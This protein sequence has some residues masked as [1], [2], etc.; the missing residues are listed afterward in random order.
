MLIMKISK[1]NR[2]AGLA[3]FIASMVFFGGC[4]EYLVELNEN[5]NGAEPTSTHPNL[6]LPTVLS[7]TSKLYLNLGYQDLAGVMQH[8]QK[9]GWNGSHN[10]YDWEG[11][12]NW[13]GYYDILRNNKF[14]LERSEELGFEMHQGVA[15]VMKSFVFGLMADL[16]GDVPY[17]EA[18]LA[19]QGGTM[20]AKYD[21]QED[22]YLGVIADLEQANQLLSK[23]AAQYTAQLGNA[24]LYFNGNPVKWRQFANSLMLRYYMRLSHK[25]PELAK[26]GIEKIVQNPNDY[27]IILVA[28]DDVTMGFPGTNAGDSWPFNL[29]FDSSDQ[30][31]NFRRIKMAHTLVEHMRA[32]QDPRL[33][34]W[35]ARVQIP[36]SVDDTLPPGTDAVIDGVRKIS[37]DRLAALGA[38]INQ[39]NQ[40]PDYVGIPTSVVGPQAFNLSPDV[41]QSAHNPHVSWLNDMYRQTTGPLLR[42][43]LLSSAEVNLI[44]AEAALK[45]W[46][47]GDAQ[48]RYEA[49]VKASFDAWGLSGQYAAYLA[50]APF[51]GTIQQVIEQK[52]VSSWTAAAEAWFDWRRTGYPDLQTGSQAMA[53]VLPVRFYYM[54]AER[55]LNKANV[56]QAIGNLESTS[57]SA[58]G[59]VGG[60]GNSAWSKPWVLQGTGDPW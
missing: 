37:P 47:T 50:G 1:I 22:V 29:T 27:P 55:E 39:I 56:E 58:F 60:A 5:P 19:Q 16:W 44:L 42:A 26:Q 38:D 11:S 52:W 3:L 54:A 30:G 34:V 57:Y 51:E 12:N 49:G 25:S 18:L 53:P 32:A 40:N 15:L 31:T 43:R 13:N 46:N 48:A 8:T 4:Q 59:A 24:D 14:V 20:T 10:N 7:E 2:K 6:V 36:I 28:A 9:D 17:S 35:A 33:G 45:G 23:P 41:N 21:R